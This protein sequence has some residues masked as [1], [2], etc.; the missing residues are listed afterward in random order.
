MR[1]SMRGSIRKVMVT[2]SDASEEAATQ[3]SIS[4]RSS[5]LSAQKAA[6]ASSVSKR[7][8]SFQFAIAFMGSRGCQVLIHLPLVKVV[9]LRSKGT[10]KDDT[11]R[12]AVRAVNA[13]NAGAARR[14]A[15]VEIA[16]L[17]GEARGVRHEANGEGIFERLFDVGDRYL[18]C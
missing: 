17:R 10:R 6:S 3:L 12:L 8:I 16:R 14:N 9:F 13:E 5:R 2:D 1:A 11:N 4:R 15:Y 18:L 7:G